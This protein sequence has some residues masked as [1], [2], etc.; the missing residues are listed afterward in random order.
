MARPD[1]LPPEPGPDAG[2]DDIQADIERTRHQLGATVGTL[3]E[4]LDVKKQAQHKAAEM[5]EQA[6]P[7]V[8]IGIFVA[9]AAVV[10]IIVW[11]RRR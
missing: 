11:R 4:K 7:A 2:V 9:V 1:P 5:R 3:T 8:P 6:T 10:G